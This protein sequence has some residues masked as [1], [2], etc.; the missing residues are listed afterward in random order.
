M[1]RGSWMGDECQHRPEDFPAILAVLRG[2]RPAVAIELGTGDG[3]FAALLADTMAEWA[4]QVHTLDRVQLPTIPTR[5]NLTAHVVDLW[6][7]THVVPAL[8]ALAPQ[9]TLLY[10]DDGDKERELALYAPLLRAGDLLGAHDYGTEVRPDYARMLLEETFGFLPVA[11]ATFAALAS[12]S[13]PHSLTR[14]WV[15]R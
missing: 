3:G 2:Y 8:L 5:P 1:V 15:R 12:P 4:G 14:F 9:R 11:H 6:V 10:C 13:Y 7:D